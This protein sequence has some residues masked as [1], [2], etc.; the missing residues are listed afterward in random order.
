MVSR[1]FVESAAK[2][3]KYS[4]GF[5]EIASS[6]RAHKSAG[7]SLGEFEVLS[8]SL[9]R[10]L[11]GGMYD[12]Y[13]YADQPSEDLSH[14]AEQQFAKKEG[15]TTSSVQLQ[16]QMALEKSGMIHNSK[17]DMCVS[18]CLEMLRKREEAWTKFQPVFNKRI[19]VDHQETEIYEI[20][21]CTCFLGEYKHTSIPFLRLPSTPGDDT[22]W[23]ELIVGCQIVD[24][25]VAL[26]EHD[27]FAVIVL[28]PSPHLKVKLYQ[29]STKSPHPLATNHIIP[30]H[31]CA[32][33]RLSVGVEIVGDYLVLIASEYLL[34]LPDKVYIFD[35]KK[36]ILLHDIVAP[37][38]CYTS[39]VFLDPAT[40]LLANARNATLEMWKI[41]EGKMCTVLHLPQFKTGICISYMDCYSSPNPR[42]FSTSRPFHPDP[43]KSL[44]IFHLHINDFVGTS[45]VMFL[46]HRKAF[47]DIHRQGLGDI[48]WD[49]WGPPCTR[50]FP[51]ESL[52]WITTTSGQRNVL[53]TR[54]DIFLLDFNPWSLHRARVSKDASEHIIDNDSDMPAILHMDSSLFMEPVVGNLPFVMRSMRHH[55]FHRF[56]MDE[57]R[58]LGLIRGDHGITD[59]DVMYFG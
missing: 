36:G 34:V 11:N 15:D 58:I 56:L 26:C 51:V 54:R 47:L 30:V 57:E 43:A 25:G 23:D 55:N 39:F 42:S 3:T 2:C 19:H 1:P 37:N 29:L 10:N 6:P 40:L 41:P 59:L 8:P 4:R 48:E 49:A 50:W 45:T 35:W 27:L 12:A 22:E 7:A 17:S 5:G 38:Q 21:G 18:D 32:V 44:I 46:V 28:D 52:G 16:Y 9:R 53:C 31:S 14:L 20:S 13:V 33:G 24:I